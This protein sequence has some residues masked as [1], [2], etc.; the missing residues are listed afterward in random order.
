[1]R[2]GHCPAEERGPVE[3]QGRRSATLL[4]SRIDKHPNSNRLCV[5]RG[6]RAADSAPRGEIE[7]K[8][9]SGLFQLG[10]LVVALVIGASMPLAAQ[11]AASPKIVLVDGDRVTS[12]TAVG[13]Q[14][15]D[16]IQAAAADW[17][18]RVTAVQTELQTLAQNRQQ[19]Q[20]TLSADA[21]A[22]LERDIEEKQVELQRLQDDARRSLERMQ[23]QGTEQVNQVLI[24]ALEALAA[25][26][27]YEMIFDSRLTQTGGLLYF[28]NSLD[29]TD[30]FIAKVNATAGTSQQ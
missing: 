1:M 17:Q 9:R 3:Q 20:L 7:M 4:R 8:I 29:V 16:R 18:Q 22:Q 10:I 30:A 6:S 23:T 12:E 26:R 13:R 14:I 27:G 5:T 15:R 21:L 19:Q 25:E 28:A 24:P 2:N 11:N